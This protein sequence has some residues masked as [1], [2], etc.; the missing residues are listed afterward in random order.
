[1]NEPTKHIETKLTSETI[2]EGR[3]VRLTV[4]TV[5]LENGNTSTR[6]IVHHGGG[7]AV[8]ALN[9]KGEVALV[10][11]YRYALGKELIEIPAGK[12]EPGEPPRE[13]ALRELEEEA[14][15]VA[16]T[17][18]D[19]GSV[20]PTCGYCTEV[21]YLYLATGLQPSVQKLDE[22][23]FVD[24]FWMPLDEAASLVLNG[25]ITD[26]KTAYGLLK[27]KMMKD[28]GQI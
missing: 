21:I 2:F 12:I 1:M 14:A 20:I 17:L 6:E 16:G 19:F 8:V 10:R 13:T 4:D 26:S 3:V 24:F 18:V 5:T 9:K 7:A 15:C 27:A 23:E 25:T 11:Q 28:T 22:D